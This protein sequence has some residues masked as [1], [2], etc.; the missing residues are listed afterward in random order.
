M[1]LLWI[2]PLA[3]LIFFLA[4]PRFRGNIAETRVR[5]ILANGL[6]KNRYIILDDLLLPSGGGTVHLDHVVLSK[7]GVFVIESQY[8]RGYI[9]GTEFQDRWKQYHFRRFTR[10]DN[11]V[12][13]NSLQREALVNLLKLPRTKVHPI[14]VM[15]GQQGFK[16]GMPE[17]VLE[18]EKL[19]RY[20]RKKGEHVLDSDQAAKALQMIEAARIRPAREVPV[21]KWGLVRFLLLMALLGGV[22]LAFR[23]GITGIWNELADQRE[24]ASSPGL[25]RTDGSR[26][27]EQELWEDSLICAYSADSGRCSCYEPDGSKVDLEPSKCQ[28]LAERGS[29]LKQ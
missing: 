12:H 23:D 26:K 14:V 21:S 17:N 7:F 29:I 27:T 25:F 28:S 2:I 20:M 4:S 9:S 3:L 8:A 24:Q 19:I 6:E 11:P 22:Y 1:H 5:R 10:F 13:R 16:T 15:V 18:P